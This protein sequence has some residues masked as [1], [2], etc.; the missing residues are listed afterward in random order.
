METLYVL[1]GTS[2]Q[3][4]DNTIRVTISDGS[5]KTFPVETL[6]HLVVPTACRVTTDVLAFLSRAGVR[7]SL[8]NY[9]G[10]FAGSLEPVEAHESGSVHL[11]QAR[12]L[13]EMPERMELARH[14]VDASARNCA[15][16]L[17]YYLYRGRGDLE[18]SIAKMENE[19]LKF[20]KATKPEELM[21]YEGRTRQAYYSAWELIHPNLR[22][23]KRTRRPP[24]DRV[25]AL[26][27]FANAIVYA[28]CKHELS[29]THLDITLSFLHAPTQARSSLALDLA[30]VFKPILADRAVFRLVMR[31]ELDDCSF[32]EHPG[33]CLLSETG[34]RR[35]LDTLRESLDTTEVQGKVGYRSIILKE[36]FKLEAHVLGMEEYEP[37]VRKA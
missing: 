7:M 20:P 10:E 25:N 19:M 3:R 16:N 17:R 1:R 34:R 2:I 24:Q 28:T 35:M 27:S 30:E 37:F 12:I 29:K 8:V 9:Y 26:L 31:N 6:R 23:S 13:F 18:D 4:K 32:V 21:A 22:L 11:A 15:S 33:V 14:F 36:A 5:H